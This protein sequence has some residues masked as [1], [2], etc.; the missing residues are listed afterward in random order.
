[1]PIEARQ[2]F[3]PVRD[4]TTPVAPAPE[5][6]PMMEIVTAAGNGS[7]APAAIENSEDQRPRNPRRRRQFGGRHERPAPAELV[8]VETDPNRLPVQEPVVERAMAMPQRDR[9]P[10]RPRHEVPPAEPLV[11]VE[12]QKADS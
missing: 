7:S 10:R 8:I 6:Q 12:T 4:T 11:Q 2:E 5:P 9:P 3:A 1:V